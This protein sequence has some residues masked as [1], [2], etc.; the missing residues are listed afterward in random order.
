MQAIPDWRATSGT[1]KEIQAQHRLNARIKNAPTADAGLWTALA[2]NQRE[3]HLLAA[4]EGNLLPCISLHMAPVT[5]PLPL[6][7]GVDRRLD[8]ERAWL[9]G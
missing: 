1:C 2:A 3:P 5:M 9:R 8:P 4:Q 7:L 6:L